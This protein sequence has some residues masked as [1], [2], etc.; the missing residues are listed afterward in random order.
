M[1]EVY[2][3]GE[4]VVK[5]HPAVPEG[6][7][8]AEAA[9]LARLA[10]AG[11]RVP[12]VVWAGSC[13]IVMSYLRPGPDDPEGLAGL[14][15]G[16]HACRGVHYGWEGQVFLGRFQLPSGTSADWGAHWSERRI[17]PLLQAT[18][19]QLGG[20]VEDVE[21]ALAEHEPLLEGPCLIH[22]DLWSG[23]VHMSEEGAAVLDPSVQWAERGVDLAMMQLFG[24]FSP[25]FWD[26]YRTSMPIPPALERSISYYQL[27]YLLVHV[28]FFG[29][30]YVDAVRRAARACL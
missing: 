7:F 26:A 12:Q 11:L 8:E 16:L 22:G 29:R 10:E 24:G 25:R 30:S 17:F 6:L 9:G 28:H 18:S 23:N 3:V 14:V 21:R 4:L 15:A 2:R 5:T 19:R 1:G 27:Y 20:V 13:G